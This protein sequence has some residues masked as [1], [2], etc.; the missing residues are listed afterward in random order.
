[1]DNYLR[2]TRLHS[3]KTSLKRLLAIVLF[4]PQVLFISSSTQAKLTIRDDQLSNQNQPSLY[5]LL[6]AEF[7][8]SRG[9]ADLALQMYKQESLSS[10]SPPVFER[11]LN[12]SLKNENIEQ[13][14]AFASQWQGQHPEYM[15]AWFYVAHLALQAHDY[16]LA[17]DNLSHILK[18]DPD[19]D[20]NKILQDIYPQ[21][22]EEQKQLLF[23]LQQLHSEDNPTLSIIEAG[24]LLKFGDNETALTHVNRALKVEPNNISYILLKANILKQLNKSKQLF[25]FLKKSRKKHPEDK[26]LYLYEIRYRLEQQTAKEQQAK[27]AWKL[28]LKTV[29]R[30]PDEPEIKL[31]TALIGLRLNEYE[32]A[33]ELLTVLLDRPAYMNQAYYHLGRIAEKQQDYKQAKH[34]FSQVAQLDL[35]L[36]ASKKVVQYELMDNNTDG[37]I[38]VLTRLRNDFEIYAPESYIMQ[39]NILK[40]QKQLESAKQLLTQANQTHKHPSIQ[41]AYAQLLNNSTEYQTKLNL[42]SKLKKHYPQNLDYQLHYAQLLMSKSTNNL[43]SR[44]IFEDIVQIPRTDPRFNQQRYLSSLNALATM[45]LANKH[46]QQ[47]IR[48]LSPAYQQQPTLTSGLLLLEGYRGSNQHDQLQSLQDDLAQRFNYTEAEPNELTKKMR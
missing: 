1:M 21:N 7:A 39:A 12:L 48:Y 43:Q 5:T 44:Q 11:T 17:Q 25:S 23:T 18:Y 22:D 15:P 29:K 3:T 38:A 33:T 16:Q 2:H 9:Q 36:E 8:H 35:V 46:Y 42:I 13:S 34:Y 6:T 31:L 41:F 19:A 4:V 45:A 20:F 40:Q 30:F 32:Q 14:L 37:A 24:L 26:R 47:V 27:K 28:A 10:D